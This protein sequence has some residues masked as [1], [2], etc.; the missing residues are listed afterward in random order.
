MTR[1]ELR[2]QIFYMLFRVEFHEVEE[3]PEQFKMYEEMLVRCSEKDTT[4]IKEKVNDIVAHVEEIDAMIN[5]VAEGWKTTRMGKVDLTLLRLAVY[6]MKYDEAVPVKVA[7]NEA[8][9]LAKNYGTDGSAAFVNG[10]LAKL[11]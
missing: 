4:Y 5:G 8:V 6:E 1:R 2:E 9:E 11:A 10:V 3:M 7:I